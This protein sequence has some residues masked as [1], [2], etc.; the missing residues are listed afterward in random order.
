MRRNPIDHILTVALCLLAV[1]QTATASELQVA[2]LE[3]SSYSLPNVRATADWKVK[4]QE[5]VL[6]EDPNP[7]LVLPWRT[8]VN[9][10]GAEADITFTVR[11]YSDH[12]FPEGPREN[13]VLDWQD[14]IEFKARGKQVSDDEGFHR[15]GRFV[16]PLPVNYAEPLRRYRIESRI[17]VHN[18]ISS[19]LLV[20][21]SQ[22]EESTS[23]RTFFVA[24]RPLWKE[25]RHQTDALLQAFTL[26][27]QRIRAF[28]LWAGYV[29]MVRKANKSEETEDDLSRDQALS[30]L[31][32]Q[33]R[34][35]PRPVSDRQMM[36]LAS[37]LVRETR[38]LTSTL[39]ERD[40][41][42][43]SAPAGS[44]QYSS[45]SQDLL[46][47]ARRI[48]GEEYS[49][50]AFTQ[51][52]HS[53]AAAT[54]MADCL[55]KLQVAAWREIRD[56]RRLWRITSAVDLASVLEQYERALLEQ[57]KLLVTFG[58]FLAK[59]LGRDRRARA[60]SKLLIT[61]V[62]RDHLPARYAGD[63]ALLAELIRTVAQG[64][65]YL[66]AAENYRVSL[67]G[68]ATATG[69]AP[70]R[71]INRFELPD[72]ETEFPD[73]PIDLQLQATASSAI[74]ERGSVA[75]FPITIRHRGNHP[76]EIH[77]QYA[78]V[79]MPTGWHR[80]LTD[81][82]FTLKPGES[83]NIVYAVSTPRTELAPE[84]LR[85][86]LLIHYADQPANTHRIAFLTR[87][88]VN[89]R[90][91]D[92]QGPD[93]DRPDEL[94]VESDSGADHI[95]P[96]QIATYRYRIT[97]D[98]YAR[99]GVR[100]R[101]VSTVPD[102]FLAYLSPRQLTMVPGG[103]QEILLKVTAPLT[104]KK[105]RQVQF[106][107]AFG[108]QDELTDPERIRI[109]TARTTLTVP[110]S[111]PRL[112]QG[113]VYSYSIPHGHSVQHLDVEN[114]GNETDTFDISIVKPAEGWFIDFPANHV[115]LGP[116]VPRT[117][118]PFRVSPPRQAES[119][120]FTHVT[121]RMASAVHPGI[122]NF[123]QITLIK[124][125]ADQIVLRP[126]VPTVPISPGQ[127][128][129]VA[130]IARNRSDRTVELAFRADPRNPLPEALHFD[131][132]PLLRIE[133]DAEVEM[134]GTVSLP[135]GLQFR[136][137]QR[138]PV[139]VAGFDRLGGVIVKSRTHLLVSP[140]RSVH[141]EM[142]PG[143]VHKSP[144][145]MIGRL[146]IRNNG[147]TRETF[148]LTVSGLRRSWGRLSKNRVT[149]D[150]GHATYVTLY[151]RIPSDAQPGQRAYLE[152]QARSIR[153]SAARSF[154][155]VEVKP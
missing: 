94:I 23:Q 9:A 6:A 52:F 86:T 25:N 99:R 113:Q 56:L 93:W 79:E 118:I 132:V 122:E 60:W 97:H 96:G 125:G 145:L 101:I 124:S 107:V 141:L 15:E 119:G 140:A 5:I 77:V 85:T 95:L 117:R 73:Y 98:G 149:L 27:Y 80:K 36:E 31:E 68:K 13:W 63:S 16:F 109:L 138:V 72:F 90:L 57:R 35:P 42:K 65:Y 150:A 143:N 110:L 83:K 130:F 81:T 126:V 51:G 133:P 10:T 144:G 78:K 33:N 26:A 92:V 111:S 82:A 14:K 28:R 67:L 2:R 152:V 7:V 151:V 146:G 55:R 61:P 45:I 123:A 49:S 142:L 40:G 136:P 131:D 102:G 128:V 12:G 137:G 120:S 70:I 112:N 38:R 114:L 66:V 59:T 58:R 135:A 22:S 71:N 37:T 50:T 153:N 48:S 47:K 139:G 43:I 115:T 3:A 105:S 54:R 84:N 8:A 106:R 41:P 29:E 46:I 34:R 108:Y 20:K 69:L 19:V 154:V 76:R 121:I 147:T 39:P 74:V 44:G 155:R 127:A 4:S 87:M 148:S 116:T 21:P 53:V 88:S 32:A 64:L 91:L 134:I 30:I 104:V 129:D 100:A 24:V 18:R 1:A 103:Q 89:G 62:Y 17:K 75:Q 11:I